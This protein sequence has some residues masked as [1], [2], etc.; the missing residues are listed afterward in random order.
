MILVALV[1]KNDLELE[2]MQ[3]G[4]YDWILF[5]S[6][7]LLVPMAFFATIVS[8]VRFVMHSLRDVDED[9]ARDKR[10]RAFDLHVLGLGSEEDK[11]D[12]SRYIE[13]WL[14][15]KKYACFLSHFKQEAAAEARI[16]KL[17]LVRG[18]RCPSNQVFLDADN[19]SDLRE[20][21]DDV[22]QSDVFILMLTDGVLSRPWC[23]AELNAAVKAQVPIVVL[24]INNSFKCP[25]E[26]IKTVLTQLP[27]YLAKKNPDALKQLIPLSLNAAHLGNLI[28]SAIDIRDTLTFDPNQSSVAIA[29]QVHQLAT[30]MCD[31]A[32]PENAQLLSFLDLTKVER[33]PWQFTRPIAVCLV[34]AEGTAVP[35]EQ[36]SKIKDW[37][38]AR[39][40]LIDSQIVLHT[41]TSVSMRDVDSVILLQTK[42]AIEEPQCLALLYKACVSGVSIVPVC[43]T[44]SAPKHASTAWNFEAAT[45]FL[46]SLASNLDPTARAALETATEASAFTVG[47]KLAATIPHVIS[48]P[49][50]IENMTSMSASFDG[51]QFEAQM[52]DIELT[53]RR[54]LAQ[55]SSAPARVRSGTRGVARAPRPVGSPAGAASPPKQ[56]QDVKQR[57][58]TPPPRRP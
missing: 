8:K 50:S 6:F 43:L 38:C 58:S 9:D 17:E 3:E 51:G 2:T 32:C 53:L 5:L 25:P 54:V 44:S 35:Q 55:P 20:L 45:P 52:L 15:K 23:L 33:E 41:S 34:F 28:L 12:L 31:Q 7:I 36:A 39:N 49:L 1:M 40:G 11:A 4:A 13:G 18:L 29:A 24:Q 27:E 19:L 56:L 42:Q 21:L 16:L 48:K 22:R 26:Q 14:V 46:Q 57:P 30:T 10:R 47:T 37:L